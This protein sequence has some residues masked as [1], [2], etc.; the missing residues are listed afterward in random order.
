MASWWNV[1]REE[2]N[3]TIDDFREKGAWGAFKDATLDAVDLVQ[4]A[5]SMVVDG[6]AQLLHLERPTLRRHPGAPLPEMG[7]EV[8]VSLS[9]GQPPVRAKVYGVDGISDPPRARVMRM[10]TG[11]ELLVDIADDADGSPRKQ[12]MSWV[13]EEIGRAVGEV[14][15]KGAGVLKDGVLDT[16]DI[17]KEGTCVALNGAQQLGRQTLSALGETKPPHAEPLEPCNPSLEQMYGDD[18]NSGGYT[19]PTL[20]LPSTG[21]AQPTPILLSPR[22]AEGDKAEAEKKHEESWYDEVID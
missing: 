1:L 10:D 22:D 4:D 14:R 19:K 17:V 8:P 16:V 3:G 15:E 21:P 9:N 18:S 2:I 13:V 20:K 11:E 7:D 12:P 6:T 5:G